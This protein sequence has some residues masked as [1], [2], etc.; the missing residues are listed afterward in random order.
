MDSSQ[1]SVNDQAPTIEKIEKCIEAL[2]SNNLENCHLLLKD[3]CDRVGNTSLVHDI[4]YKSFVMLKEIF[5]FN[6]PIRMTDWHKVVLL[7]STVNWC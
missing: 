3:L 7:S 5:R 6:K 1:N 4:L 2:Q